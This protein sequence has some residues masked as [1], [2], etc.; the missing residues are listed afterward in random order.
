MDQIDAQTRAYALRRLEKSA[1][2][3]AD[4]RRAEPAAIDRLTR[5]LAK[6]WHI[7]GTLEGDRS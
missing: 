2:A 3:E 1:R 5:W 6:G 4:K 7:L